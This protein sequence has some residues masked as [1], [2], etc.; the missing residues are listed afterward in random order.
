MKLILKPGQN[1]YFTSDTHYGHENICRG[2]CSWK[3]RSGTRDFDTIEQMNQTIVDRI[4]QVVQEDDVLFH[5][6]DWSFGGFSRVEE[7]RD[8]IKCKNIHIILGNH[9]HHIENDKHGIKSR[10]AS[11]NHYL[12]LQVSETSP[13]RGAA[14]KKTKFVLSHYPICS[15]KDMYMGVF[16]LHGHVHLPS[17]LVVGQGKSLDVGMDGSLMMPYSLDDVKDMLSG[18]PIKALS[19]QRD[20]H[21][22]L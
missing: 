1:L 13:I 19:L 9:D 10:F 17:N 14:V 3:D 8:K 16:H 20:H 7:F 18:Q 22:F 2:T 6:G 12:F 5:L 15:W 4:N 21:E 11:V